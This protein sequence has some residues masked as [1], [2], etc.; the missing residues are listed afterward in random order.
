MSLTTQ[1]FVAETYGLRVTMEQLSIVL[2]MK[3]G[4]LYNHTSAGT[5]P[6]ITYVEGGRRFCDYRDLAAYL[7]GCRP[8]AAA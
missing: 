5:L 6:V 4:T 1:M 7:D 2:D 3:L 8:K